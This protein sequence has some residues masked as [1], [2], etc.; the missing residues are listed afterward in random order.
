MRIRIVLIILLFPLSLISQ[1][2]EKF[3]RLYL[4]EEYK[5]L[6]DY[7]DNVYGDQ[8]FKLIENE[9]LSYYVISKLKISSLELGKSFI[10]LNNIEIRNI[11]N[12]VDLSS[13]RYSDILKY[14]FG[15]YQYNNSKYKSAVKYLSKTSEYFDTDLM[16]GI[17][18]FNLKDF[19]AAKE[20][21]EKID[22]YNSNRNLLLGAIE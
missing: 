15:K 1:V 20:Y 9:V 12:Y 2:K 21:I 17:S 8:D 14:E 18:Y 13:D 10:S 3:D 6:V 19:K 16:L 5:I 11:K 22:P 4:N 7:F